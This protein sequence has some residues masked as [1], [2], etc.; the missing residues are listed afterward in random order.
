MPWGLRRFHETGALHFI[1]WSCCDRQPLLSGAESRDLLLRV[2][3][4]MRNRYRFGVVGFVVM[5]EH[6]H[7]LISAF[8]GECVSRNFCCEAWVYTS[9]A[10]KAPLLATSARSGAPG[11]AALLDEEELRF[12]RLQFGED[13]GEASLHAPE[14]GC[15]E[16][17]G[18]SGRVGVE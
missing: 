4:Q 15:S 1:T 12:Q 5:P 13:W 18:T 14:S 10:G 2:V 9:S 7:L 6:V 16:T 8:G 11:W 17:G 3:E